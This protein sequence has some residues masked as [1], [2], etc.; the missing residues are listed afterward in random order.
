MPVLAQP[1]LNLV[2]RLCEG[3]ADY[4]LGGR[5]VRVGRRPSNILL[6][7]KPPSEV[8]FALTDMLAENMPADLLIMTEVAAWA[9]QQTR[10]VPLELRR[11]VRRSGTCAVRRGR[12]LARN[13][14]QDQNKN[15]ETNAQ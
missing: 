1:V 10:L 9:L 11:C 13:Y 7:P 5:A 14:T 4:V 8:L 3:R 2:L 12:W 15:P 6:T